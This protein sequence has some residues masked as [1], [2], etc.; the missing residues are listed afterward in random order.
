MAAVVAEA[1]CHRRR[2]SLAAAGGP[3]QDRRTPQDWRRLRGQR[4]R[5]QRAPFPVARQGRLEGHSL[6][7]LEGI[8]MAAPGVARSHP[9]YVPG[10]A[11][12]PGFGAHLEAPAVGLTRDSGLLS[13]C[14]RQVPPPCQPS[15]LGGGYSND[16]GYDD[17]DDNVVRDDDDDDDDNDNDNHEEEEGAEL[18]LGRR[19]D[20]L[21]LAGVV[22]EVAQVDRG[23]GGRNGRLSHETPFPT[24][25]LE[26]LL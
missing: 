5:P 9:A 19:W 21:Q 22:V 11:C 2:R 3:A 6:P 7:A 16:G 18:A 26:E 4:Q 10:S 8:E 1:P 17:V 12:G 13:T 23:Q 14:M 24:P 25:L 15:P 20:W